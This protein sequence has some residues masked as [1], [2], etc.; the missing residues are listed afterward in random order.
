MASKNSLLFND[1]KWKVL[2]SDD[3]RRSFSKLSR[4]GLKNLVLERLSRV[5]SGWRPKKKSVDS[6]LEKSS[7]ILKK[8]KV[9]ELYIVCTIDII[10][11]FSYVQ[12]LKVWDIL[13]LDDIPKLSNRLDRLFAAYTHDY[14]R[15]CTEKYV[16]RDLEIPKSWE[17]TEEIIRFRTPSNCEGDNEGS[18]N[19][20]G[21][22][23]SYVENSK[24][25]ESLLL[26]KFYNLSSGV[27]NHLLS[28]KE[29]DL[30]MQVTD[31]Q[32]E[33]ILFPKSWF[34]IGRSGTGKTTI[35]TMKL[36]QNE[37]SFRVVSDGCYAAESSQ[38]VDGPED[39]KPTV[40]RQLFVTVSTRL[41]YAVKKQVSHLTSIACN[42]NSS[43]DINLDDADVGSKFKEVIGAI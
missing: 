24:V 13:S 2:F 42:G 38:A 14:I 17:T 40:L 28:G 6:R 41:C 16:H 9:E 23:R 43:T 22:G 35:L 15:R 5:S 11:E 21:D 19:P 26:M 12:V 8:F 25:S 32:M 30:P 29:R 3:F 33:I 18:M 27:V 20:P 37:E 1:A 10:K 34:I 36:F 4:S 7:Q 31:E 39:G